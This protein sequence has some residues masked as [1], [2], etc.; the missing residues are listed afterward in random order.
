MGVRIAKKTRKGGLGNLEQHP[1]GFLSLV[2]KPVT[3]LF[4]CAAD[5]L[6]GGRCYLPVAVPVTVGYPEATA[7]CVTVPPLQRD[8]VTSSSTKPSPV[9]R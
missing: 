9:A 2:R 3:Q 1:S 8:W 4:R 6:Y 7:R 5:S